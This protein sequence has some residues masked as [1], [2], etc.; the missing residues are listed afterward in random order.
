VV[1]QQTRAVAGEAR[2]RPAHLVT[3][4]LFGIPFAL[5]GLAQCW[6][7]AHA[8]GFVTHWPGRLLWIVTALVYLGLLIRYAGNVARTGRAATEVGDRTFGPFTALILIIPM[9]LGVAL[10]GP[11]PRT[12]MAIFVVT[13]IMV[14]LYGG[15]VSGQ[16]IVQTVPLDRWH[17]GYF[18]PTVAGP[19]L[20]A[21]G[22]ATL[23][24]PGV[25]RVLLGYGL[26]CWVV[27]G[28]IILVRL[29]TLPLPPTPLV[30]TLA[31]E[32]APPVVAGSAWFVINGDRADTA[33]QLL[34]GY[35]VLMLVVQLR[36]LPL[37]LRVPFV[38]GVW[39][40]GFTGA[41]AAT[42]AVRWLVAGQVPAARLLTCALLAVITS[43][44][45]ALAA[46]TVL[47]LV[48]GT[49]LLRPPPTVEPAPV[50]P[51]PGRAA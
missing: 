17:P 20:A 14:A 24:L 7:T 12:G 30:P 31:I 28:S 48:R 37:Y 39:A 33:A 5:A 47:G 40:Y 25:A 35:A 16:W 26:V 6:S 15:W 27:L 49:F 41:A 23:G 3:A 36:L 29:F 13:M 43:G 32:L 11:A 50:E 44:I 19:L 2:P 38:A 9:L 51:A 42:L 46:R 21:G 45:L 8:F 1:T 10:S 22:S 18:L 34:A 4:N